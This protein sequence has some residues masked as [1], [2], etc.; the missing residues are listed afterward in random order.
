MAA[1]TVRDTGDTP[2]EGV[3]S[4]YCLLVLGPD[5]TE[6]RQLPPRGTL[7]IGRGED[8]D[9][10]IV[11]ALASRTHATLHIDDALAIE[12]LDSANGTRLRDQ[13]VP[14][15]VRLPVAPGDSIMIGATLLVVQR[16]APPFRPRRLWPHGYFETRLIEACAQAEK[17]R[18]TF[19]VI[20]LHLGD[21]ERRESGEKLLVDALRPG[22]LLASYGPNEYEILL[23]DSDRESAEALSSQMVDDLRK[24]GFAARAGLAFF[25]VDGT[26]PQAL[27]S[28]ACHL[29]LQSSPAK[30]P[31]VAAT[32]EGSAIVLENPAMRDLYALAERAARGTINVLIAGETGVGKE[33]LAETV[34]RFSP[35]KAGPFVC[36]NCA[37]LSDNLLESELFGYEKGAFTGAVQPKAGLLEAASSGTLFLDEIGEMSLV[38]Q[39]KVLRA[40]ETKQVLRVGATKPRA[41]DVRF[42][43]ATNRDLEE[44]IAGRRFREDL[45]FRL[46]GITLTIPPLR[47]RTD[48]IPALAQLFLDA[49][50][51]QLGETAPAIAP[52]AMAELCAYTWPG[53]I[54]ELRNTLER[55]L[56]LASGGTVTPEHLPLEKMRRLTRAASAPA[57]VQT[58]GPSQNMREIEKQAIIDALVRCGG[59]QTRAAELLGMPR[60][61]FCKRLAEYDI[62]RPHG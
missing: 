44:E 19:A 32:A 52:E 58:K 31:E 21:S 59:N 15:K 61:T 12:D 28:R 25:P 18:G 13:R 23:V 49:G 47:E 29:V 3:P 48:E 55:A 54:R 2:E 56:L 37:A 22:D 39:A 45:Y 27:V 30:P 46:N 33:I 35:R 26:S 4:G 41:V 51:R 43:A 16:G 6:T 50:A 7:S 34:H 57:A 42:V 14:A 62:P 36:L 1:P 11:D 60:R 24:Q 53:N 38:L 9:I 20:R 10:R 8:A 17:A 5:H 40:I